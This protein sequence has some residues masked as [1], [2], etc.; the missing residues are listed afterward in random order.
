MFC[1]DI[2]YWCFYGNVKI[3]KELLFVLQFICS[4]H[5]LFFLSRHHF[6]FMVI[7]PYNSVN[8][9]HVILKNKFC[10]MRQELFFFFVACSSIPTLEP[11]VEFN[12]TWFV[13]M[14]DNVTINCTGGPGGSGKYK[15][16]LKWELAKRTAFPGNVDKSPL[17][18]RHR[19]NITCDVERL[20]ITLFAKDNKGEYHCIRN[21][22]HS[23]SETVVRIDMIG[24]SISIFCVYRV[25]YDFAV[26][27]CRKKML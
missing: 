9:L 13:R 2:Y 25:D 14:G 5:A 19:S 1:I 6:L 27:P 24:K 12:R 15:S 11:N 10:K 18:D 23:T 17:E 3:D 7:L 21:D 16:Y 22:S 26:P 20:S 4:C 8:G